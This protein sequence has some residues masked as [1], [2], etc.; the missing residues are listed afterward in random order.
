MCKK[1][2]FKTTSGK[3]YSVTE[4]M[5]YFI[6][7][8]DTRCIEIPKG[9]VYSFKMLSTTGALDVIL[10]ALE[11]EWYVVVKQPFSKFSGIPIY[12]D[13]KEGC[14]RWMENRIGDWDLLQHEPIV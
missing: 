4:N 1:F 3:S 14:E 8:R 2:E 12:G 7:Q 6:C 9:W 13:T 10:S 5:E 11:H